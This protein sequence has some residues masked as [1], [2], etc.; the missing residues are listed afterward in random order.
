M[1][2]LKQLVVHVLRS[3]T[4]RNSD[5]LA[6]RPAIHSQ[7]HRRGRGTVCVVSDRALYRLADTLVKECVS[8]LL[9]V[10][11]GY[12]A[13]MQG[14]REVQEDAHCL[15]A[16]VAGLPGCSF[17]GVFDGHGGTQSAQYWSAPSGMHSLFHES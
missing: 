15:H 8:L 7:A 2:A 14:W 4:A 3:T 5:S 11:S 10:C 12:S 9:F 16:S 17:F 6:A 13:S 1:S